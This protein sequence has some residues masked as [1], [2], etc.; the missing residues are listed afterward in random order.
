[1]PAGACGGAAGT[2]RR[3]H[4]ARGRDL[5][6]DAADD[7]IGFGEPALAREPPRRFRQQPRQKQ[8]QE[9]RQAAEIEQRLP[10]QPRHHGVAE[11]PRGN[12]AEDEDQL[13]ENVEAAAALAARHLD[14]VGGGDRHLGAKP[15]ALDE[16]HDNERLRVPGE[17]TGEAHHAENGH[18]DDDGA[19]PA[20]HFGDPAADQRADELA[21]KRRRYDR[22]DLL[23]RQMP[24]PGDRRQR[25]ADRQQI[26]GVEEGGDAEDEADADMPGRQRQPVEPRR[27]HGRGVI[28]FRHRLPRQFSRVYCSRAWC[29]AALR[30]HTLLSWNAA[31]PNGATASAPV[32][33]LMPR[34]SA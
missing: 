28:Q 32:S 5:A 23:R 12:E 10:S 17:G 29:H 4:L 21:E 16:A 6:L 31:P 34:P 26:D 30:T 13:V 22:P 24:R 8:R 11:Q 2:R 27:H 15:D 9:R 7:G 20:Q 1:M 18:R 19:Q 14:Y 3:Q 25:E 33:V